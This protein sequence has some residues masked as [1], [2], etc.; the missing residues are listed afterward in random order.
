MKN[1]YAKD[2]KSGDKVNT[3]FMIMKKLYKDN[4]NNTIAYIGDNSGDIKA[5]MPDKGDHIKVG[6]VIQCEASMESILNIASFK[7]VE[8]F[9]IEEYLP[10]IKTPVEDIMKEINKISE[11]EFKREDVKALN[12]YFFNDKSFLEKFE[13]GIGGVSMHHNYLGGLAEH[14][15]NV[16][17]LSKVFSYRYNCRNKEIAILG[18]KLH[19]IGKIYEYN[20]DGPFSY[21]L[22]GE[23][24]GHIVI[25]VTMLEEAFKANPEMYN[26]DFRERM[27]GC[28]VQH[29]GKV[30]FGSPKKPSMEESHIVHYADYVDATFN[31]ISQ[32]KE[33][34]EPGTWS[35]YDRRIDGKLYI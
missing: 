30:E 20:F 15:L 18:A 19:D 29:H 11:E 10:T 6:D 27:K 12:D 22:R 24:E 9:L 3:S 16:M 4:E 26:E 31:K 28:I 21:T 23:M 5:I 8:H 34:L 1:L 17:Y 35:Q 33:G 32:I 7:K 25:G 2:I 14:T 13:K